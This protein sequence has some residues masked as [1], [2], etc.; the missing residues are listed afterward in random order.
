MT[1][2][3]FIDDVTYWSDLID[4]CCNEGIS[5]CENVYNEEGFDDYIGDELEE[6]ARNYDWHDIRS[7]LN[8]LPD[9]YEYYI[10]NDNGE[11]YPADD[12]DFD[13]M[14]EDVLNYMDGGDYWDEYDEEEEPEE[15]I[16]PEDEVP[17][18]EEDMTFAELFTIC[19][20]QVQKLENAK[21]E[22]EIATEREEITAFVELLASSGITATVEGSN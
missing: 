3:E 12:D 17:V 16:D 13:S 9:R 20:S 7:W 2:Q 22:D 14:K 11:W 1:R 8:D 10:R 21:I 6:R 4:F 15:H 5:F 18:G 19:S